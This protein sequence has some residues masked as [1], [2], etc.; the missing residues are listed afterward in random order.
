M[1]LDNQENRPPLQDLNQRPSQRSQRSRR[2]NG[3]TQSQSQPT[4]SQAN[5]QPIT[6]QR[7]GYKPDLF[8]G[9]LVNIIFE[10]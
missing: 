1:S 4:A 9:H 2:G 10:N 5:R 6:Y 7:I 3:A 8:K